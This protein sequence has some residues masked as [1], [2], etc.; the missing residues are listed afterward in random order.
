MVFDLDVKAKEMG[1]KPY[2]YIEKTTT[3]EDRIR[4]YK[5]VDGVIGEVNPK[6][7]KEVS[8]LIFMINRQ[9]GLGELSVQTF[10]NQYSL[11]LLHIDLA[12]MIARNC[13]KENKKTVR[14]TKFVID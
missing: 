4:M 6:L 13:S 5:A 11:K 10:D 7:P 2:T 14:T 12:H 8:D 9:I 1:N 3:Q